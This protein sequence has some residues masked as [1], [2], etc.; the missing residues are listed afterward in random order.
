LAAADCRAVYSAC[1]DGILRYVQGYSFP[2]CLLF[3]PD[4]DT[5]L[6]NQGLLH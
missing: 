5:V 2:W 3:L 4:H 1:I 6:H